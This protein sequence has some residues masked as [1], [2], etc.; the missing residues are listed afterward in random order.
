MCS[1][2]AINI[3]ALSVPSLQVDLN[4][5]FR[6]TLLPTGIDAGPFPR[7]CE[8]LLMIRGSS[9]WEAKDGIFPHRRSLGLTPMRSV[10]CSLSA[11]FMMYYAFD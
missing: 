5:S 1:L 10:F 11:I 3:F 4:P 6:G 7:M 9:A 2:S 8:R